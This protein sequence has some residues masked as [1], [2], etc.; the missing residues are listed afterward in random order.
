ME[1]QEQ[2]L[3]PKKEKFLKVLIASYFKDKNGEPYKI[4][5]GQACMLESILNPAYKE[6]WISAI[7]RYGK[8]EILAMGSILLAVLYHLKIPIV[9]GSTNKARK[10]MEYILQ[11]IG[12]HPDLYAGLINVENTEMI[13][14][15]KIQVS[16][17]ALR[18][19][20]GGWIYVTSVD[21]KNISR[22]GEGVVGEGGDVVIL[23]EA[24]LI[25]REEQYSK[26]VRM[27][28]EDGGWGKIIQSGNCIEGSVFE[29]AHKDP[30]YK[31]VRIGL[32]QAIAEGRIS[33]ESLER[34]KKSMTSK[35][36][37]RYML[38]EFPQ[39]NE[40]TYFKP[41]KYEVLPNDLKYY[42]ALDPALGQAKQGSLVGIVVLAVDPKGQIY[43]V[44]S[45]GQQL[46][47]EETIRTIFNMPYKFTR[48]VIES[49]Q[50]Q[51]YF[52]ET[53]DEK[54]KE[55]GKRIPFKGV[56]QKKDKT[57]RIE[58]LEPAINTGQ[59]LFKGKNELWKEMQDYPESENLD[60][61]DALEMAYR[62]INSGS[63][64]FVVF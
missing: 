46:K 44:E 8:S 59:I 62:T 3:D 55:L 42:G 52:L 2:K 7:T 17:S 18:W 39:E 64:D 47:P 32:E 38:V 31:K 53:I 54:S 23:E 6:V 5:S 51:K 11:H 43:E 29:T 28:E 48:F 24:G 16:K 30:N 56:T 4:T 35:D 21:S 33:E 19:V 57:S 41:M 14:K 13:D 9:A 20:Q 25:K 60:V 37:K 49:V 36:W 61:M 15:L 26:I 58:S 12:D 50:F 22:E 40:Y 45:I 1:I 27:T 63:F 10:I 34:K